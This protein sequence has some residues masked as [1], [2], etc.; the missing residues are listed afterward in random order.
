MRRTALEGNVFYCFHQNNSG[1]VFDQDDVLDVKVIVEAASI[2]EANSRAEE[3]GIYFDGRGDCEC[4]GNRW[5]EVWEYTAASAELNIYGEP[6]DEYDCMCSDEFAVYY[7]DN[8]Y[9]VTT[10][11]AYK[12]NGDAA[13]AG[14]DDSSATSGDAEP[15]Y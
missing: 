11:I 3:I 2:L 15:S 1:G 14:V 8:D 9:G 4:C 7:K 5:S 12:T 6:A 10:K 13:E